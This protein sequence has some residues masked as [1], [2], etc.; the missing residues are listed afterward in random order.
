[1]QQNMTPAN[2]RE[3]ILIEKIRTLSP[4]KVTQAFYSFGDI[5]LVPFPFTGYLAD[6]FMK[7]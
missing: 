3:K 1:M 4:D 6:F 7:P 5:V 2:E